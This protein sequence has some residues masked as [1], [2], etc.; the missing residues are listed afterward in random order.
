[1][2]ANCFESQIE[3]MQHFC[4]FVKVFVEGKTKKKVNV[5]PHTLKHLKKK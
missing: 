2:H 1:V 3:N 5:K 4:E